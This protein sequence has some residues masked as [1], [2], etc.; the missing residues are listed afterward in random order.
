M[1]F[2]EEN[3]AD[4]RSVS[5]EGEDIKIKLNHAVD[6]ILDKARE[7]FT[8]D[9]QVVI[10]LVEINKPFGHGLLAGH[11]VAIGGY[12]KNPASLK[13]TGD[14]VIAKEGNSVSLQV[15]LGLAVAEAGFDSYNLDLLN[16]HQSGKIHVQIAENS[17]SMKVSLFYAPRC[18]FKLDYVMFDRL[19]GIK[20]DITGL[21]AFQ[22]LFNTLS[23]WLIDNFQDNLKAAVNKVLYDKLEKVIMKNKLCEKIQ[24]IISN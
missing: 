11:F 22:N 13:R 10:P 19:G 9:G 7:A 21:G 4:L 1:P 15:A 2:S 8:T 16:I 3:I 20:V 24:K 14:V 5:L 23:K 6:V 12:F 18:S 17:L